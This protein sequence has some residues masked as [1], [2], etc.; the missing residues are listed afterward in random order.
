MTS[1][2]HTNLPSTERRDTKAGLCDVRDPHE[3]PP[4]PNEETLT[5]GRQGGAQLLN[6]PQGGREHVVRQSEQEGAEVR[7]GGV[8]GGFVPLGDRLHLR[9]TS[10]WHGNYLGQSFVRVRWYKPFVFLA[11]AIWCVPSAV[12]SAVQEVPATKVLVWVFA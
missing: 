3:P 7:E 8:M 5:P 6:E 12:G 4:T 10:R 2:V 11:T 9:L 1:H